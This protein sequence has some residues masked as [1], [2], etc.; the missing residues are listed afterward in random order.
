MT[1]IDTRDVFYN[2]YNDKIFP[3]LTF[4]PDAYTLNVTPLAMQTLFDIA[5]AA[6]INYYKPYE[7]SYEARDVIASGLIKKQFIK[8]FATNAYY[9]QDIPEIELFDILENGFIEG[10]NTGLQ[11]DYFSD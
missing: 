6:G 7:F 1:N 10:L 5:F 4:N 3:H 2:I 9:I 8:Q 11:S